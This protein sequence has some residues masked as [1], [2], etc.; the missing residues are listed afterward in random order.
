MKKSLKRLTAMAVC[1]TMAFSMLTACGH[2]HSW[3][4][5]EI[6]Q[7]ASCTA[8]GQKVRYCDCGE[9]QT[10]KISAVEHTEGE[11][12]VDQEATCT[13]EGKQHLVCAVCNQTVKEEV[14]PSNGTHDYKSEITQNATCQTVGLST[15]T[16]SIC[17]DTYTEQVSCKS[18]S[19]TQIHEMYVDSVGE[20]VTYDRSGDEFVLGSCFVYTADGVVITNY[21]VIEDA[22]SVKITLAD[23]T[24]NVDY[25]LAYDKNID[26]AV[27]Q[28]NATNL[29]PV[30]I[31]EETHKV[32][33]VVYAFGNSR[34]LTSTF[35][36]GMITYANREMDG[37]VYTQHDAP[38][39]GGNSGGPL[40]NSYGEVIGIN[41]WTMRDSQNL[42]FAINMSELNNL[43]YGT[44]LTV[45]QLY[46]KESNVFAKL[47]NYISSQGSY[48]SDL[49]GYVV[50]MGSGYSGD[51][52]TKFTRMAYYFPEEN[53]IS[54][55]L[56]VDDG[57]YWAY[58]ELD[59][60]LSGTYFWGYFDDFGYR[61]N[62]NVTAKTFNSNS[63]LA[64]T[65][66]N[67]SDSTLRS[68]IHDLAGNLVILLLMYMEQDYEDW[69]VTAA[70]IGF[71]NF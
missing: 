35:S 61:M 28:I 50:T 47:C 70:D 68:S 57:E 20:V 5:W 17:Q 34:G 13:Q 24:Y 62:G 1:F 12:I 9:E 23:K 41:T 38:I 43:S 42:N 39:S 49:A 71:V 2:Q 45:P 33:E 6:E 44:K 40:I 22:Y 7:E 58:I 15:F 18:Y 8:K 63:S 25:V 19:S 3:S 36:D 69:G 16:C 48:D 14:I 55:D 66:N 60:S 21:H 51:Y 32:G 27:L 46:E 54:L 52:T 10:K 30:V 59:A 4:D 65:Y 31:C 67:I 64:Y 29:K 37:V 11:W 26:V 56:M 53:T